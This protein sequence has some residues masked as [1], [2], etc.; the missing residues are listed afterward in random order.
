MSDFQVKPGLVS[1]NPFYISKKPSEFRQT[2]VYKGN[3]DFVHVSFPRVH[4]WLYVLPEQFTIGGDDAP[5]ERQRTFKICVQST[6]PA[7]PKEGSVET[8]FKI[9]T[10]TPAGQQVLSV[11]LYLHEI[12]PIQEFEGVFAL[13]FGTSSSC[14][15]RI[16]HHDGSAKVHAIQF[17]DDGWPPEFDSVGSLLYFADHTNPERPDLEIGTSALQAWRGSGG[18]LEGEDPDEAAGVADD[19]PLSAFKYSVK[20]YLGT[21]RKTYV[22]NN[23]HDPHAK[24][25]FYDYE[26]LCAFVIQKVLAQAEDHMGRRLKDLVVTYPTTFTTAQL[27][28]LKRVLTKLGYPEEKV[29]LAYDEANA[30]TLAYFYEQLTNTSIL[31]LKAIFP[32]P[33]HMLTFDFGGGTLDITVIRLQIDAVDDT[34]EVKTQ[35]EGVA[36]DKHFGGDNISL[37]IFKLLKA[38][39]ALYV[40]GAA[41]E[42]GDV[43]DVAAYTGACEALRSEASTIQAALEAGRELDKDHAD[44]INEVI[45]SRYDPSH[46]GDARPR[47]HFFE[48]WDAAEQIKKRFGTPDPDGNYPTEVTLDIPLNH[49]QT[50]TGVDLSQV[51]EIVLRKSEWEPRVAPRIR[52][53]LERARRLLPDGEPVAQAILSGNSSRL[54]LVGELVREVLELTPGNV[55]FDPRGCKVA[56]AKGAAFARRNEL[57]PTKIRYTLGSLLRRL[58]WDVGAKVE[59]APFE[60]FY[61]RGMELPSP[62]PYVFEPPSEVQ[63]LHCFRRL[64]LHD[65]A[66]EEIGYFKFDGPADGRQI[67]PELKR[68]LK[69]GTARRKR[70]QPTQKPQPTR[71]K[72]III[73]ISEDRQIFAEKEGKSYALH[74]KAEDFP[75]HLDPFS[76]IH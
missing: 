11:P 9:H 36:G 46:E 5:D 54:P 50:F 35:V 71:G 53:I 64:S 70:V 51:D 21:D 68:A 15:A 47:R 69:D 17:K 49:V 28:A 42:P 13:D 4:P 58:P 66:P 3:E 22:L 75:P 57:V 59:G 12:Q 24:P 30:A 2:L 34:H 31:S 33:S 65:E 63:L 61:E 60:P 8:E 10:R 45:P 72:P 39:L 14:C 56:V 32:S 43:D 76:G 25:S 16:D 55:H 52:A 18:P 1:R 74:Y 7:F 38:R 67:P 6:H 26:Q 73:W 27:E 40:A 44:L 62:K 29:N 48:L 23:R 41:V 37:E 19:A 20:R